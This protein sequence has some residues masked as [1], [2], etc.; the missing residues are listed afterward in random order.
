MHIEMLS[1]ETLAKEVRAKDKRIEELERLLA[2]R[3]QDECTERLTLQ[4]DGSLRCHH[5]GHVV[6]KFESKR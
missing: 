5:C 1:P 6:P 3:P 4:P 2:A